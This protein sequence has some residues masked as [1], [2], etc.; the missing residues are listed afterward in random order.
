[1]RLIVAL[2][3]E[4]PSRARE[5]AATVQRRAL[6]VLFCGLAAALIATAV[7]AL[8]GAGHEPRGWIVAAAAVALAAW[9]GSVGISALRR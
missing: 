7:A 5:Y 4:A 6:G 1:V 3:S 2:G 9:L 8:I